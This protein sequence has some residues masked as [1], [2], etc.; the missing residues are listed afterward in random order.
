MATA[1]FEP[2]IMGFGP[3]PAT[4]KLLK[5]TVVS[6]DEIGVTELNDAIAAQALAVLGALK[7]SDEDDRVNP[8]GGAIDLGHPLGISGTRLDFDKRITITK[9][10]ICTLHNAY[11]CR[12]GDFYVN[13]KS[14]NISGKVLQLN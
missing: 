7:L 8:N 5:L 1:G 2:R 11:R 10:T 4:R 13:R 3:V 6:L 12:S 9:G 14:L